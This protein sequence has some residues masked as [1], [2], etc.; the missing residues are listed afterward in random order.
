MCNTSHNSCYMSTILHTSE[1]ANYHFLHP[2]SST[3]ISR[4][5]IY[6]QPPMCLLSQAPTTASGL[7]SSI[8]QMTSIYS[9]L[10]ISIS[11]LS[12]PASHTDSSRCKIAQ[13]CSRECQ[14]ADIGL[15]IKKAVTS[16]R[17]SWGKQLEHGFIAVNTQ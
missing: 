7:A 1:S 10:S 16:N 4:L 14:V 2:C 13:Y 12:L 3:A 15:Y 8:L 5:D 17:P 6:P 9:G 11:T